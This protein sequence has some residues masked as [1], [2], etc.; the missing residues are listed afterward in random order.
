MSTHTYTNMV[1]HFKAKDTDQGTRLDIYLSNRLEIPRTKAQRL[2]N[3]GPVMV[4]GEIAK[5]GLKLSEKDVID[6]PEIQ[7]YESIVR[8][9]PKLDIL[10]EDDDVI[11]INKPAGLLVHRVTSGD[12]SPTLVDA[13]LKYYP[14]IKSVGDKPEERPGIV[15]RLDKTASGVMIAAKNQAAFNHL[16]EQFSSR[17]VRKEYLALVYGTVEQDTGEIHFRIGRSK[18]TG[19]MVAKPEASEEGKEA[20]SSYDVLER[21]TTATLL[22]VEIK[23]GRTHQ[24]RAHMQAFNHPIV[25]DPLYKKKQMTNIR[26]IKLDRLFLHAAKLTIELPSGETKTFEAPLP[27]ELEELLES[28]SK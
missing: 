15:H 26:P 19:K 8:P 10:Y 14:P 17:R 22:R 28:L 4:N 20:T 7:E 9:A 23:T 27:T 18:R 24:I 3:E 2:I 13:L 16:K 6:V 1:Q 25:G 21:F 11:V 12:R 5:P